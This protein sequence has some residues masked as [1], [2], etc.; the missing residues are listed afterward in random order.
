MAHQVIAE[1]TVVPLG[2]GTSLS[3][4]VA[5]CLEK[6]DAEPEVKYELTSMGTIVLG[7]LDAVLGVARKLHEVPF[8]MGAMRVVTTL[9]IDDRRDKEASLTSKVKSVVQ[10]KSK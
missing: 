2:S 4:Y 5:A 6:L 1:L 7:P 8:D 9:K 3:R 10:K